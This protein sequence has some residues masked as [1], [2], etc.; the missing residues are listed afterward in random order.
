M[1]ESE[2]GYDTYKSTTEKDEIDLEDEPPQK[3]TTELILS[4]SIK[5]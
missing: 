2:E 4:E 3:V 1:S 5:K